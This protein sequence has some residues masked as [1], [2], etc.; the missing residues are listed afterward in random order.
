MRIIED[1]GSLDGLKYPVVTSGTF[2]GLH[3]GHRKILDQ[4]TR[5]AK[6]HNGEGIVITYWPH[7]RFVL[8]RDSSDLRLLSTIEERIELIEECGIDYLVK[9]HFTREFSEYSSDRY[10]EE[11]LVDGI[12]AKKLILGYDHRFGKDREGGFEY[13]MS[14]KDR[15]SFEL[16]EIPRQDIDHVGVSSTKIRNALE[17]GDIQTANEY[18]GRPYRLSGIVTKGEQIGRKIGYPTANIYV[19]QEYKLI[20]GDGV[21][22]VRGKVMDN[23]FLGMLNIGNRPTVHGRQRTIE[24]NIFNF[25]R[26][27]YGLDIQVDFIH[28][29]RDEIRFASLQELKEQ[30]EIDHQNTLKYLENEMD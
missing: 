7:P 3:L 16:E 18:L 24:V 21:Y 6:K 28:K 12:G 1:L 8:G 23:E 2:D 29:L 5:E 9:I 19:P 30:L 22:V 4:V 20:P 11:I 26:D 25:D 13:L 17:E 10:I 27:I 15:Y 14:N